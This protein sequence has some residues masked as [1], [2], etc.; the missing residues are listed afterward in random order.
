MTADT[1]EAAAQIPEYSTFTHARRAVTVALLPCALFNITLV[2]FVNGALLDPIVVIRMVLWNL[3]AILALIALRLLILQ[4]LQHITQTILALR[5]TYQQESIRGPHALSVYSLA[6]EVSQFS[7]FATEY[8][9]KHGEVTKEL[10]EARRAIA[11]FSMQH[12][13][14]LNSTQREGGAQYQAV[15]AYA[16]YLEERVLANRADPTLRYDFDDVCESSFS[17]SLMTNAMQMLNKPDALACG[18]I[19]LASLLQQTLI[20][21]APALDRR[22]MKLTSASVDMAVMAYGDGKLIMHVIWMMLFG[23]IRY[24]QDESTL[25]LRTLTSHD[26]SEAILSIVIS[27]LSAGVLS[28]DERA[29]FLERQMN[30]H[31]PHLFADAVR[32]HA[33]VQLA[34]L[35]LANTRGIVRV[36][37]LTASSCELSLTLPSAL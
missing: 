5:A 21:L 13:V 33:N 2:Y 3:A 27:E 11:H 32:E 17:L 20:K 34:S 35:L 25:R 19:R 18:E 37:P 14:L 9:R 22:S 12:Q 28:E 16:N 7:Q 6:R 23:I 8:Y 24:A 31:T 26:G 36:E 30:Y 29:K 1:T 10:A 4:P 15:L